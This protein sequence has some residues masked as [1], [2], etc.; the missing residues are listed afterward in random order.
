MTR[1]VLVIVMSADVL[2]YGYLMRTSEFGV[3]TYASN[4]SWI[5]DTD[6]LRIQKGPERLPYQ[7]QS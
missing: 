7:V 5:V 3:R 4:A 6:S 1:T 2:I